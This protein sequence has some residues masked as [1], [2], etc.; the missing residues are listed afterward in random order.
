VTESLK[1]FCSFAEV[2]YKNLPC[3]AK[4]RWMTLLQ[5][6]KRIVDIYDGLKAYFLSTDRWPHML[7]IFFEDPTSL[8]WLK[9][10]ISEL[11]LYQ[12]SIKILQLENIS[13]V[14]ASSEIEKLVT[15]FE[16]CR[17]C[18]FYTMAVKIFSELEEQGVITLSLFWLD[19]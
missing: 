14:E 4:T 17:T 3:H 10:L 2:E 11:E 16:N 8:L 18:K 1:E 7:K 12:E 19:L 15:K 5:A 9:F 13:I 6:I